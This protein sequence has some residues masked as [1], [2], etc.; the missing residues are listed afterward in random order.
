MF[1]NWKDRRIDAINKLLRNNKATKY[2]S[3]KYIEEYQ[4]VLASKANNKREYKIER[5]IKI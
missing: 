2:I 5:G 4:Y 1:C 3:E